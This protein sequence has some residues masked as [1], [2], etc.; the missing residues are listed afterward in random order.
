MIIKEQKEKVVAHKGEAQVKIEAEIA[1]MW[2][3][4]PKNAKSPESG[5]D[6]EQI[7]PE[8]S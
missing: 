2:S 8:K 7:L 5:K 4:K 3:T 1:E 6:R